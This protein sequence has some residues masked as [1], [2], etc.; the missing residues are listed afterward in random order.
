[1]FDDKYLE[2]ALDHCY[3][4]VNSDTYKW[5]E[6]F[7]DKMKRKF[8]ESLLEYYQQKED[9][10]KCAQLQSTYKSLLKND[11]DNN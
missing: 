5:P 8:I 6:S 9:Y 7:S 4:I 3:D 2:Q 10:E 11:E 1:M